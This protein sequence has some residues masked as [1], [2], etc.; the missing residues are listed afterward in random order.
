MSLGKH[1][2]IGALA[3]AGVGGVLGYAPNEDSSS[4]KP[5]SQRSRII[6]G[7]TGAASIG[8]AGGLVGYGYNTLHRA[9][10]MLGMHPPSAPI[11]SK[12]KY[13]GGAKNEAAKRWGMK[14]KDILKEAMYSALADEIE[15]IAL[16]GAL[17]GGA[18][19]YALAPNSIKG[20][21]IGTALGAGIGSVGGS[22]ARSA[23]NSFYTE[24][25]ERERQELYS[26]VPGQT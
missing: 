19:G 15:K 21:A 3:G 9:R 10:Q 16:F 5:L 18:A 8:A 23:K 1:V 7:L 24:P 12:P 14:E 20:K 13:P 22:L 26:Y 6:N 2:G 11:T 17:A 4:G 25:R